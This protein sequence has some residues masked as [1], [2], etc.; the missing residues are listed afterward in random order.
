V[1]D[2]LKGAG[3]EQRIRNVRIVQHAEEAVQRGLR[4]IINMKMLPEF[5][6]HFYNTLAG[7]N[8]FL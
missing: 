6:L 3:H 4:R 2:I 7:K 8:T 5:L 1:F